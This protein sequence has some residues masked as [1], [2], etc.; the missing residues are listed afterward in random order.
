MAG[1]Y[2]PRHSFVKKLCILEDTGET[3]EFRCTE[4][5]EQR[6]NGEAV[7]RLKQLLINVLALK[8]SAMTKIIFFTSDDLQIKK[9]NKRSSPTD[10][11]APTQVC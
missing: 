10:T 7:S 5:N 9:G 1:F 2:G 11:P 4:N 3:C 8:L 6:L